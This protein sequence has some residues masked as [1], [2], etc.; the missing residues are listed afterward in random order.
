V[1][2]FGL[3]GGSDTGVASSFE[4]S[5]AD[6][7]LACPSN[8]TSATPSVIDTSDAPFL[9]GSRT[10]NVVDPLVIDPVTGEPAAAPACVPVPYDISTTCPEGYTGLCTNFVYDALNQGTHMAF[11][12]HWEWPP[13]LLSNLPPPGGIQQIQNTL[14]FFIN[15]NP[16]GSDLDFCPE[17]SPV[18]TYDAL[19]NWTG[20]ELPLNPGPND[21]EPPASNGTQ[22]GCL[23]RRE[24]IQTGDHYQVIEDAYVQGDYAARRN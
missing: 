18:S 14:Q 9:A 20:I 11:L 21:R 24:V 22:A 6:G 5:A 23:L 13:Q 12:F 19:G 2:E 4:V 15:G 16:T 10:E 3:E 8:S 7:L 17:I 1:G